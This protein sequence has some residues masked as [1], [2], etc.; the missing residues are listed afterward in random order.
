MYQKTGTLVKNNQDETLIITNDE[1]NY[2]EISYIAAFIWKKLDG[3]TSTDEI[4]KTLSD[5]GQVSLDKST[6]ITV[7]AIKKLKEYDLVEEV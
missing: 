4:S 3:Q 5:V 1:K 6:N 2:Y 7:S